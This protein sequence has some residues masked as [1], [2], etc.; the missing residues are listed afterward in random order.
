MYCNFLERERG[1]INKY[2]SVET[3]TGEHQILRIRSDQILR[4]SS[5]GR[6]LVQNV[7]A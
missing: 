7:L 4:L 3:C 1:M 5:W 6:R 2:A